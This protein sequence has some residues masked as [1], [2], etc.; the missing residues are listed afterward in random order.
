M[1]PP[2]TIGIMKLAMDAA[3]GTL[4]EPVSSAHVQP[5]AESILCTAKDGKETPQ[6]SCFLLCPLVPVQFI[7]H[8][9]VVC[10]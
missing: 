3:V 5:I 10:S 2:E 8:C 6:R 7:R 9:C 4:P 1:I